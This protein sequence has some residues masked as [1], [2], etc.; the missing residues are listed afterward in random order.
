MSS[1]SMQAGPKHPDIHFAD[2]ICS[3]IN[4]SDNKKN[5]DGLAGPFGEYS[6]IDD[7][8]AAA[9]T[10]HRIGGLMWELPNGHRMVDYLLVWIGADN[11]AFANVVMTF[12][13]CEIGISVAM[14]CLKFF[15]KFRLDIEM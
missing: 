10:G 8:G 6:S 3:I 1:M 12:N 9:G 2:V 5:P 15:A 4:P 14:F 13:D 7:V 11:S